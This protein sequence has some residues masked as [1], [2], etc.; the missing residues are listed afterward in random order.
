M[1]SLVHCYAGMSVGSFNS[2]GPQR[3]EEGKSTP[4]YFLGT[5]FFR[6]ENGE[7]SGKS[8]R[9]LLGDEAVRFAVA[10]AA[11]RFAVAE[12]RMHP[13]SLSGAKFLCEELPAASVRL[14]F[15]R[16]WLGFVHIV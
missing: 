10:R 2:D 11:V 15:R 8:R 7:G 4:H 6:I 9:P 13:L 16:S 1:L 3:R 12:R 5:E 14:F